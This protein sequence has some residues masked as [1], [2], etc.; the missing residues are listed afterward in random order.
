M[1]IQIILSQAAIAFDIGTITKEAIPATKGLGNRNYFVTTD[2]GDFVL[3][4]LNTQTL[5]GLKNEISI[6]QQL[7]SAGIITPELI[8]G[9]DSKY[10]VEIDG[11]Y[12]TCSKKLE[13]EHPTS[14][15]IELARKIG[16]TLAKFHQTITEFPNKG[17]SWLVIETAKHEIDCLPDD[18]LGSEIRIQFEKSLEIF[19]KNLPIGFIHGDLHFANLLVTKENEIA[20]F[21]FEEADKNILILDIGMSVLSFYRHTEIVGKELLISLIDGYESIKPLTSAEKENLPDAILYASAISV[22]WL[23]NKKH[24]EYATAAIQSA[25]R[26][27]SLIK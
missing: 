13:G 8:S 24:T 14:A 2:K 23:Y 26:V 4:I 21:D 22:A 25:E 6:E 1:D 16:I 10:Y 3:R 27:I 5:D 9:P 7:R 18:S 17:N 11:E 19:N 15:T 12:I 20:I